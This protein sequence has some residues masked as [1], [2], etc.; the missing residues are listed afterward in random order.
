MDGRHRQF[1]AMGTEEDTS[2]PEWDESD[3]GEIDFWLNYQAVQ[4]KSE[5]EQ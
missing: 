3:W 4:E 5:E 1:E 2:E